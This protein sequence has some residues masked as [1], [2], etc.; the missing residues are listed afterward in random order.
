LFLEIEV[1]L[2]I[3][4]EPP[5]L[6]IWRNAA[7]IALGAIGEIRPFASNGIPTNLILWYIRQSV[8]SPTCHV[9]N[10]IAATAIYTAILFIVHWVSI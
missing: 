7:A 1:N 4:L 3:I 8:E 9:G 5:I 2:E 6:G 10:L